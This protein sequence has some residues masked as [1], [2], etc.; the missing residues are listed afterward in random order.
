[1][2]IIIIVIIHMDINP[3]LTNTKTS[4]PGTTNVIEAKLR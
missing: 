4:L 3:L 2:I 1:M